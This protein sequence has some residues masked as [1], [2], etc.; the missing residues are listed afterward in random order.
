V[1]PPP[2]Q[3]RLKSTLDMWRP[4]MLRRYSFRL[5]ARLKPAQR[6]RLLQADYLGQVVDPAMPAMARFFR[7]ANLRAADQFARAATLEYLCQRYR[8][9]P[10]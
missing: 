6:P 7:L 10:D 1:T 3:R 9:S 8:L 2:W 5:K 4:V